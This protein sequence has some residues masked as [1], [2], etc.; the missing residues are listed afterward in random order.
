MENVL[1]FFSIMVWKLGV[2]VYTD[3]IQKYFV[4]NCGK[5]SSKVLKE[6]DEIEQIGHNFKS[7][8]QFI[9]GYKTAL[10]KKKV[11]VFGNI[12]QLSNNFVLMLKKVRQLLIHEVQ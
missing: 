6:W 12:L 4:A 2:K 9:F 11:S 5:I 8:K 3:D 1:F 10:F 7:L